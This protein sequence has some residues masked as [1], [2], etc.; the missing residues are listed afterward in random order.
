[1]VKLIRRKKKPTRI[2]QLYC[3]SAQKTG[4]SLL[5]EIFKQYRF[6]DN[7]QI[8]EARRM[9]EARRRGRV[10]DGQLTRYIRRRDRD[11]LLEAD[12]LYDHGGWIDLLPKIFS[13]SKYL[14]TIR[15]CYAWL[16]ATLNQLLGAYHDPR[17]RLPHHILSSSWVTF[18]EVFASPQTLIKHFPLIVDR[19]LDSW[20][21]EN[22]RLLDFLPADRSLVVTVDDVLDIDGRVPDIARF[23]GVPLRSLSREFSGAKKRPTRHGILG[24]VDLRWLQERFDHRCK[25]LMSR[26][27]PGDRLRHFLA[28]CA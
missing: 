21:S 3:V 28:R 22:Q 15:N 17:Q 20:A 8:E 11:G 10:T 7:F 4:T 26:F 12:F 23:L 25:T 16:D 6:L 14:L 2:F 19:Y 18:Q 1:M 27:F 5:L 13:E 24:R 9:I